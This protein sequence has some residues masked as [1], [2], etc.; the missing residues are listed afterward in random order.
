MDAARIELVAL[1]QLAYSG[2]LAAAHAYRGHARS[3][4]D[5][6]ERERIREIEAEEWHHRR[7]VGEM[8]E[9]LGAGP[10][11]RRER[12]ALAIGRTLGV[13]CR[14]VGWLAPMYGAGRLESRNVGEYERAA[15]LAWGAGRREWVDELLRMAEVEWQHEA[16]FRAKVRSHP[17]G[18][19]L[20]LWRAPG[21]LEGI[22]AS[23]ER[24]CGRDRDRDPCVRAAAG[25]AG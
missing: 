17:L 4:G 18:R 16:Y 1:L 6:E 11:A 21:P 20:P 24:E 3:V 8:L 13:L 2:E 12:R 10:D 25:V 23:F 5:P 19:R 22:R 9:R 15:R 14:A 7:R